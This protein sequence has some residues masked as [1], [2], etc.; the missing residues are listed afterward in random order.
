MIKMLFFELDLAEEIEDL[1]G[2]FSFISNEHI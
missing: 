2:N 1:L